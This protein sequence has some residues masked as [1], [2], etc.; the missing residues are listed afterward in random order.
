MR[1]ASF[2]SC[3]NGTKSTLWTGVRSFLQARAHHYGSKDVVTSTPSPLLE[4]NGTKEHIRRDTK[5]GVNFLC[6]DFAV[7][8]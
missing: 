5:A 6:L 4:E 8:I 2:Y 7:L 3:G 1:Q